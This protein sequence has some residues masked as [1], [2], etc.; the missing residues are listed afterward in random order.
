MLE[1]ARCQLRI[2]FEY[3]LID[4]KIMQVE[5]YNNQKVLTA[6]PQINGDYAQAQVFLDLTLPTRLFLIFSGKN[7][8]TDTQIDENG[9]IIKDL[10]VKITNLALD[11]IEISQNALNQKLVLETATGSIPTNY[12]GFNGRITL[13]LD[14]PNVFLQ[15]YDFE[16]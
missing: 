7:N 3:G 1:L 2:D 9:N 15:Y 12:V 8:L 11:K 13:N 6:T 4:G 5:I 16:S 10:Y 14:K